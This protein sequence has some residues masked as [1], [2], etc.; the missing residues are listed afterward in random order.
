MN[1]YRIINHTLKSVQ[2][3][4]IKPDIKS[5]SLAVIDSIDICEIDANKA[6]FNFNRELSFGENTNSF[7]KIGYEVIIESEENIS[8]ENLIEAIRNDKF[9]LTAI[10]SKVSLL[11]SE[12]TNLCPFGTLILAP[13]FD[14]QKISIK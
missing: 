10:L 8:K 1:N 6:I 14:T 5:I 11:I 7:V 2:Y 13:T 12:I 9:K 3:N 4:F